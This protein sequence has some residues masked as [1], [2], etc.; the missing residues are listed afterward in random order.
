MRKALNILIV[1]DHK[2]MRDGLKLVLN[3]NSDFRINCFEAEEGLNA[4]KTYF[5]RNIDVI[6]MDI[7]LGKMDGIET[8]KR[9]LAIDRKA[10]IIGLSNHH[11][12]FI[13]DEMQKSG[14]KGYVVKSEGCRDL[15]KAINT[16]IKGEN[17]FGSAN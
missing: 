4:L 5:S 10:K 1:D 14:A 6:L 16:I 2:V 11:E 12:K 13:I 7:S 17:F 15:N 8:S 9:I 3:T